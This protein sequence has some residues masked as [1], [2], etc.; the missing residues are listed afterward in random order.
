MPSGDLMVHLNVA[1]DPYF[2]RNGRDIHV[3]IP[4][5][6]TQAVLGGVGEVV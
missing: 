3:E 2:K 6:I 4:I 1:P 5:S